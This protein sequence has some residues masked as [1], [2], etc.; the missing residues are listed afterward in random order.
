MRPVEQTVL[1]IAE[2][3]YYHRQM[4]CKMFVMFMHSYKPRGTPSPYSGA[5]TVS[6]SAMSP[7]VKSFYRCHQQGKDG[8]RQQ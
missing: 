6:H 5:R 3:P 7:G 1:L 2:M 8:R 4:G